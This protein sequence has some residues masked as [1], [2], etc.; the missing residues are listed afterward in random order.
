VP[1]LSLSEVSCI[2]TNDC[3]AVG[4]AAWGSYRAPNSGPVA[5]RWDGTSWS[6]Q[7]TPSPTASGLSGVSCTS[8]TACTAVGFTDY[9]NATLAEAWNGT[10]WS[11]QTTPN[12]AG[13]TSVGLNAVSCT[14][15]TT[16]TAVGAGDAPF[17]ERYS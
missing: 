4:M 15:A 13:A 3:I 11:I 16:C 8:T 17:A 14:S 10:S 7:T 12:P 1:Y 5:E 9:N 2:S 6:I